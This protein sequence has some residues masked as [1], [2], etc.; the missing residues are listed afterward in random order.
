MVKAEKLTDIFNKALNTN[1][2]R[3]YAIPGSTI[4]FSYSPKDVAEQF[5]EKLNSKQDELKKQTQPNTFFMEE[6][7]D[8]EDKEESLSLSSNN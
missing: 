6:M 5:L 1:I 8:I 3:H 2:Q 4:I 7:K